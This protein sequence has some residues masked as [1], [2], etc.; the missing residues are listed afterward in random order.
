MARLLEIDGDILIWIQENLRNGIL[1]PIMKFITSLGDNGMIWIA[2]AVVLLIFKKTR[3]AGAGIALAMLMNLLVLN[4][5]IKNSVARI[6]PY[7]AVE[8]LTRLIP[9]ESSY[10]FPSGHAGHAFAAAVVILVMLPKRYGIPAI[11]LAVAIAFSR[12]Y[13]GVHYLTDVLAGCMIGTIM[14]ALSI[15]I[16]RKFCKTGV[17]SKQDKK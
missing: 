13:V 17:V 14:A 2:A 5:I 10:S 8:G 15:V 11:I 9:A 4:V 1:T 7:E 12:L 3:Q 16:V 6:R